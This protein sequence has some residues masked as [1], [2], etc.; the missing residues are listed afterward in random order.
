[1]N[2]ND[3]LLRRKNKIFIQDSVL[4][5]VNENTNHLYI[6]TI[7]TN[8]RDFGY[9]L[10]PKV[11]EVLTTY[12]EE[13]LEI[14]YNSLCE[15]LNELV[16]DA[17][18]SPMFPNFPKHTVS[19][20]QYE[21]FM[22]GFISLFGSEVVKEILPVEEE[23][24]KRVKF[25]ECFAVEEIDLATQNDYI[26]IFRNI[27]GSKTSI[28]QTDKEEL[29]WFMENHTNEVVFPETFPHKEVLS[30][31][32]SLVLKNKNIDN[33][34]VSSKF[35]TATD[36]LRLATALSE[37]DESLSSKTKFINFSRPMR[38]F[39]LCTLEYNCGEIVEDMLKNKSKWIRL[40]ERLHP[41]EFKKLKKVNK[42]FDI[43]RNKK[44][45]KTFNSKMETLLKEGKS[46]EAAD[47]LK[48]RPGV[49]ARKLD[50]ILR[51]CDSVDEMNK[52]SDLFSEVSDKVS[53]PVLLQVKNHF[54]H[55]ND[56]KD[57]R[58]IFPKGNMAEAYPIENNLP[59]LDS[60][61]C[62]KIIESCSK[63]LMSN[64]KDLP[65]LG[66][67]YL[68]EK[69]K[70]YT[71]PFSQRSASKTMKTVSR[72]SKFPL[73]D[74][75]T[76]R[77]FIWW[78]NYEEN[79]VDID[80]SSVMYDEDWKMKCNI[81]Y[82]NTRSDSYKSFHS[83]DITDAPNGASEFIDVDIASVLKNGGR[84]IVMD[85]RSFTRQNFSDIPECFVGWMMRD[86]PNSGEIYDPRT[87]SN[88]I[89]LGSESVNNL[90]III[91]L[92]ERKVY[93]A[94][95]NIKDRNK[96]V[97]NNAISNISV[98]G[99]AGKSITEMVKPDLY[100]LFDHHIKSRNGEMVENM[101]EADVIF[102]E[103]RGVTP[104]DIDEIVNEYLT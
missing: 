56:E 47:L 80:L 3:V 40:G 76:I 72:G 49:F 6:A 75:G 99:L 23:V 61:I 55:R 89:D 46:L 88:K 68:D 37:G 43:L 85:V 11:V 77:F 98:V 42:A 73:G 36:V 20:F 70:D 22:E 66:K 57:I 19:Q 28:S 62:N 67:V 8:I 79:R 26:N 41:G 100:D 78:K 50:H 21:E 12:S 38:R 74:K 81:A 24:L 58:V 101:E 9:T 91:D 39:I 35:K 2:I 14:F 84:Y 96:I 83:G 32:V 30:Y 17:E 65:E 54:E 31:V 90:P 69:L 87:V 82:T 93:W 95:I 86:K 97:P 92:K 103:D 4:D 10:T 63:G 29:E 1:M 34:K 52:V 59:D 16:G 44:E 33:K 102:S 25:N 13:E 45:F 27:M 15:S 48:S 60:D 71:V 53:T 94:D 104:Y 7:Q 51:N 18:Y 64:F 5:D